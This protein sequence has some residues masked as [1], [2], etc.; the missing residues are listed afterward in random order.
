MFFML[1]PSLSLKIT[2]PR[3]RAASL[4]RAWLARLFERMCDRRVVVVHAPAGY[5]KTTLLA[6]W[7]REVLSKR[8]LA[9]WLTLD[10]RDDRARFVHGLVACLRDTMGDS[11]FGAAALEA[12]QG[13]EG[14]TVAITVLLAGIVEAAWPT[15]AFLDDVHLLP[16]GTAQLLLPYLLHNL[17]PNMQLV[18]GTRQSLRLPHS[19]LTARDEYVE[20]GVDDLRLRVEE[21]IAFLRGRFGGRFDANACAR[22]HQYADGWPI[23]LMLIASVLEH[24]PT[25]DPSA[26][27]GKSPS[28]EHFFTETLL[29]QLPPAHSD[30]LVTASILDAVHPEL[31]GAMTGNA[32]VAALLKGLTSTTPIFTAAE[33]SAWL[34]MHPLARHTLGNLFSALPPERQCE[35]HWRAAKWLHSDGDAEAAARHAFAAGRQDVAYEWISHQIHELA[36]T[37]RRGEVLRWAERLPPDVAALPEVRLGIGWAQTLS[38][39]TRAAEET[40]ASLA[41]ATDPQIRYEADL[42]EASLAIFKDDHDR[43][44]ALLRR[45]GEAPAGASAQLQQIHANVLAYVM[46]ERG[47]SARARYVQES[48]AAIDGPVITGLASHSGELVIGLSHLWNAQPLL[49]DASLRAAL[50]RAEATTGRRGSAACTLAAVRGAALWAQDRRDDAE[51]VLAHRLDVVERAS[52]PEV[53]AMMYLTL[54][55]VAFITGNEPRGLELLARLEVI[56]DERRLPRLVLHSLRE[57]IRLHATAHRVATAAD[58]GER[59]DVCWLRVKHAARTSPVPYFDLIRRIGLA[60]LQIATHDTDAARTTL[61]A[62]GKLAA[63]LNRQH[64]LL[65]VRILQ[66]VAADRGDRAADETLREVQ[67]I[68]ESNGLA[69]LFVDAHPTAVERVRALV[70]GRELVAPGVSGA[71]S[72]LEARVTDDGGTRN[73]VIRPP[74]S[75][76][77]APPRSARR[78][79]FT[80]FTAKEAS[81]LAYLAQGMSNKE[82]ARALDLGPETVKWHLKNVFAKLAAGNRQHA[83]ARARML[84]LL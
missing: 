73:P 45:R 14:E 46:I 17:P 39:Q 59:L 23:A 1:D 79:E 38:Y 83:V 24:D 65:E 67:S 82:I 13:P 56:G 28:I 53:V 2:P 55:R 22:I 42:I 26:I 29:A 40:L 70:G 77:T 54:A 43:M 36:M 50:A 6:Q 18:I 19:E 4:P 9:G 80:L 66:A 31:L 16:E 71:S 57:Q 7:R 52:P 10:E 72:T 58:L 49:A 84:G 69:R 34:R 32:D 33:D 21:S 78:T 64:D 20:I 25:L 68:A 63:Q 35:L 3:V 41:A 27:E 51:L 30:L 48:A 74:A 5:G 62:A 11:R 76:A 47:E 37:S 81:M 15:V 8:A 12:M 44:D 61:A 60:H 75:P